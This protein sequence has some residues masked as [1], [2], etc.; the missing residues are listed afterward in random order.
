M[1]RSI[2][3]LLLLLSLAN[4]RAADVRTFAP[5]PEA[6]SSFG[7]AV[8]DGWL[9]H[10][11][12]HRGQAHR[13]STET[14]SG[15]FRR[16]NLRDGKAWED[17]PGG[18]GL[19]GLAL[20]TYDGKLYRIGGMQPRNKPGTPSDNHSVATCDCYDPVTR[21]WTALPDLPAGRSSHDAVVIDGKLYVAGG[22]QMKGAGAKPEW[23][24]TAIVLDL[25]AKSPRWESI[26][27]PFRRRALTA[28]AHDGK[29]YVIAGM[30]DENELELSVDI[31][32]PITGKWTLGKPIPGVIGNGFTPASCVAGGR[33]YVSPADGKLWR[34]NE[35]GDAWDDV[36]TLQQ[37]RFVHR[38]VA[39]G[40]NLLV[41]VGGASKTGNVALTEAIVPTAAPKPAAA[42]PKA[43]AGGQVYCPI[44]TDV[45]I[46]D[47]SR[48][49]EYRGV[50]VL[51]CCAAC[52]RK[53]NADPRAYL[54]K[55][56]LPQLASVDLPS[57][58]LKQVYCPV[59]RNRV[60]SEKDP[61]VMYRG[62]KVY[63]FNQNA[64]RRW[65]ENPEQY[66]DPTILPQLAN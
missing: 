54:D 22:W 13:Y 15:E 60:I 34:L 58:S 3:C 25:T 47:E 62:K 30:T 55:A 57:R 27:Q 64:V 46:G 19:Q 6:V 14:A 52:V 12:G 45:P 16:L 2:M 24:N 32:D 63:L 65:E 28:T 18:P 53:W 10:Y 7:A 39:A 26:P 49:V 61:F 48:S 4:A 37:A 51:V 50:K 9:Y 17:L 40:D 8:C 43:A 5:L 41:V 36:G 23:H 35:K 66:A 44:M 31:Y 1:Q 38:M 20:V 29:M 33:L 21:K 56:R 42:A 59:Y 11:G